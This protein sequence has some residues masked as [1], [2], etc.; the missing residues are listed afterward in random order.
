VPARTQPFCWT[1]GTSGGAG[2]YPWFALVVLVAWITLITLHHVTL[3]CIQDCITLHYMHYAIINIHEVNRYITWSTHTHYTSHY[4]T[5]HYPKLHYITLHFT[6]LHYTALHYIAHP[7]LCISYIRISVHTCICK[8]PP[9]TNPP[10]SLHPYIHNEYYMNITYL[11]SDII[12]YNWL[13][14]TIIVVCFVLSSLWPPSRDYR[15]WRKCPRFRTGWGRDVPQYQW[16]SWS[17]FLGLI[18]AYFALQFC[19]SMCI[20]ALHIMCNVQI[21]IYIYIY[22]Y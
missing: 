3:N 1:L 8:Y 20:C 9:P 6:P 16:L 4:T 10:T 19:S 5:L 11:K 13:G 2:A 12:G 21:H 17:P 22:I 18:K 7:Y 15:P 14:A